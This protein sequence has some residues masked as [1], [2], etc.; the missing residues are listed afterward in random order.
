[1]LKLTVSNAL[2]VISI[3]IT[4]MYGYYDDFI[5]YGMH[6]FFYINWDYKNFSIQFVLYNFLHGSIFHL[7]FNS[8]FLYYFWNKVE[9]NIKTFN[10]IIFFLITSILIWI[11][12][13]VFSNGVTIW[14]S[15]FWMAILTYYTLMLKHKWDIE[16]KWWITA[17]VINI[18]IW[19]GWWISFI[20][21]LSWVIIWLTYFY[22][23]KFFLHKNH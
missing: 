6:D 10:Y 17:I 5:Y 19:L 11:S 7:L 21:H 1:M 22:F 3:I 4:V 2:I 20:G 23:V 13:I 12:L 16:Y 18:L 14:I 8:I 15:W 9:E